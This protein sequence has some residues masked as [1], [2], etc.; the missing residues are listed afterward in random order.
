VD[1][2]CHAIWA[3]QRASYF[4]N[5][6]YDINSIWK[7]L[8]KS[9]GVPVDDTTNTRIIIDNIDSWSSN[10]D[11]ALEY[12]RCLLRVCQAYGL[13]LNLHRSRFFPGRFEF[14]GIDVCVG[15]NRPAKSKHALLETWPAPK[16]VWDVAKFIGFAQFYSRFIH[17]LSFV[18]P[19]CMSSAR[20]ITPT[21]L[22]QSGRTTH[23]QPLMT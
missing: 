15:G 16:L 5:F 20:M 9:R 12:I 10:E 8:A 14:V 1:L 4:I 23:R 17:L 18:F 19:P 6:I 21:L 3:N 2:H 7:E 13:F 22:H 11:Y